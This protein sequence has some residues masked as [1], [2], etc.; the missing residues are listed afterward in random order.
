MKDAVV[1]GGGFYGVAIATYLSGVRGF[2]LVTLVEQDEA[3]LGRASLRNQARIHNG[4]HYPRSLTTA[5][6][7]RV[8]LPRFV[9]DFPACVVRDFLKIYAIARRNS[10]VT[11]RQFRR[12]CGAIGARLDAPPVAV[13]QLFDSSLVEQCF[14]VEEP[15]LDAR[16]L[17]SWAADALRE[18]GV[19]RITG[20]R[21][22]AIWREHGGLRV[23]LDRAPLVSNVTARFVFNCTYSGLNGFGGDFPGTEA[24]LKHEI[25]EMALL[26]MPAAL[27]SL[28]VT[29]MDGPFFSAMPYPTRAAHS[30]SHV[31]YTPHL[32]WES[33]RGED[34][35]QRLSCHQAVSRADWMLRDATR[36]LP[37]LEDAA[38][39]GS[40]FEVKT[41]LKRNE[42]DDG[43]PI[44]F[45]R[46]AQL[47]GC[48][49]VLGGKIDNVY[50]VLERLDREAL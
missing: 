14:L 10:R 9:A 38:Y 19:R 17:A 40:L 18:H 3:L 33:R 44:L 25:T 29:V 20:V 49:S 6:R 16:R 8:N 5:L 22:T 36:Y 26:R 39:A 46:H 21:A 11:A 45:E 1:I 34:A 47:A 35:Y 37:A 32:S 30:L 15:A 12:F 42:V 7:S 28:G 43:R 4:Y 24:G 23:T 41:I 48:Y 2:D 50:D 31:R 27:E 13:K